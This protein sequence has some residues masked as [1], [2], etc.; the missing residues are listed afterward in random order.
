MIIGEISRNF[1]RRWGRVRVERRN[2]ERSKSD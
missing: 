2:I 1:G